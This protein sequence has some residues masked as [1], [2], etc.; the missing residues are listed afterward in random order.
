MRHVLGHRKGREVSAIRSDDCLLFRLNTP[1]SIRHSPGLRLRP[2]AR[3][4]THPVLD[5]HSGMGDFAGDVVLFFVLWIPPKP[6]NLFV[7]SKTSTNLPP[8]RGK[9]EERYAIKTARKRS[10]VRHRIGQTFQSGEELHPVPVSIRCG[11]KATNTPDNGG[12][13]NLN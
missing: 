9:N 13:V 8:E 10:G 12:G 2:K 6:R 1:S 11:G 7:R 4:G 5:R 3:R